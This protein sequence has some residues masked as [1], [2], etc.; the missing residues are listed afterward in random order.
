MGQTG[1]ELKGAVEE[2]GLQGDVKIEETQEA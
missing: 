2:S 1:A